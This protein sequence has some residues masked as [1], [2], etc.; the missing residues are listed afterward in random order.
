MLRRK[1]WERRNQEAQQE[2]GAFNTSYSLFSEPYKVDAS[3]LGGYLFIYFT[4]QKCCLQKA[5]SRFQ[6]TPTSANLT[7]INREHLWFIE[8]QVLYTCIL[9]VYMSFL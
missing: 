1:E 5:L 6:H 8:N 9:Y 3:Q 2:D 7:K 4:V